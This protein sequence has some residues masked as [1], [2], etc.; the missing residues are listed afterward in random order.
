MWPTRRASASHLDNSATGFR[1][2][3]DRHSLRCRTRP[4]HACAPGPDRDRGRLRRFN[5]RTPLRRT[6]RGTPSARQSDRQRQRHRLRRR[7]RARIARARAG[8]GSTRRGA[9]ATVP[10]QSDAQRLN[11]TL[12]WSVGDG[13]AQ[14][15]ITDPTNAA[16]PQDSVFEAFDLKSIAAI[17]ASMYPVHQRLV[18]EVRHRRFRAAIHRWRVGDSARALWRLG[19]QL[20]TLRGL[21]AH[22]AP[23][24]RT[25]PGSGSSWWRMT[26]RVPRP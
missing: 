2:R 16:V 17:A 6:A 9:P 23:S 12:S 18:H 7:P 20:R 14:V 10:A 19:Q 8:S 3:H 4:A 13:Y 5:T 15:T 26:R 24:L 1:L 11:T 21:H 22:V 25:R